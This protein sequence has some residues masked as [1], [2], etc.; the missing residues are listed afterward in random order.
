MFQISDDSPWRLVIIFGT[1]QIANEW[2]RA[3]STCTVAHIKGTTQ[4]IT[5]QF[6]THDTRSWNCYNFFTDGDISYVSKQFRGKMF[7]VLENDKPGRGITIIPLQSIVDHANGDW[8]VLSFKCMRSSYTVVV[9][10]REGSAFSRRQIP[11]STGS[12]ILCSRGL[13]PMIRDGPCSESRMMI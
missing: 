1:R 9:Y 12:M 10:D 3:M 5:P 2:W 7:F 11:L 6:Y 13:S 4:R 8:C